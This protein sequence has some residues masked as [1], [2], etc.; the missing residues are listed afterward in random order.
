MMS[1]GNRAPIIPASS[2]PTRNHLPMSPSSSPKAKRIP[3]RNLP[4]NVVG[5]LEVPEHPHSLPEQEDKEFN[6]VRGGP[7]PSFSLS[8][9]STENPATIAVRNAAR[10]RNRVMTGSS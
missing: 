6:G 9:K 5:A 7:G 8:Y 4:I 2:T 3:E 10:G 1:A